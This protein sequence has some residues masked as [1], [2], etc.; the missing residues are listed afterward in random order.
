MP[1]TTAPAREKRRT[2]VSRNAR[3]KR[4]GRKTRGFLAVWWPFLLAIAVTPFAIHAASIMA[5]E[6]PSA[7]M[8]LYPWVL[9]LKSPALGLGNGFGENLSQV[10]M[11]IQFPLYGLLMAFIL[12]SKPIWIALTAVA[13]THF[14]AILVVYLTTR[15]HTP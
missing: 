8:T 9:L 2:I 11:Y 6:G 7:L 14:A 3:R 13:T 5:L 4:K 12:R 10:L 15:A 1:V